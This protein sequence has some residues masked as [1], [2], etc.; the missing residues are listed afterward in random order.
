MPFS[1]SPDEQEDLAEDVRMALSNPSDWRD[2]KARMVSLAK[3]ISWAVDINAIDA[4]YRWL[5]N[6]M[7][8]TD[9]GDWSDDPTVQEGLDRLNDLLDAT[10]G[11]E[12]RI[13]QV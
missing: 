13:G 2:T 1:L 4:A 10:F 5:E 9:E 6:A 12:C 8:G 3:P 11:P 7:S